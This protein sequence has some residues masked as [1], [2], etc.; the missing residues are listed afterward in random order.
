VPI[1]SCP[2]FVL[3]QGARDWLKTPGYSELVLYSPT[4]TWDWTAAGADTDAS[5]EPWC[6]AWTFSGH[7]LAV[8]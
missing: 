2:F 3:T 5:D 4:A 1:G 6:L 8:L 7:F